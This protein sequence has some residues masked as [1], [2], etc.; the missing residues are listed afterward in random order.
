LKKEKQNISVRELFRENL[1]KAEII[2]DP[3]LST[4]IMR[5]VARREFFRF[6]PARLN[7]YYIGGLVA[8][9]IATAIIL[10]SGEP[11]S[12]QS[13]VYT[14]VTGS[15]TDTVLVINIGETE[16]VIKQPIVSPSTYLST[17]NKAVITPAKKEESVIS[18][19]SADK[20]PERVVA[21]QRIGNNT[22]PNKNVTSGTSSGMNM[23]HVSHIYDGTI[24]EQSAMEGCIPLKIRFQI[25][26]NTYDSCRWTFGDGGYSNEK[27]PEWI[28]DDEGEYKVILELYGKD[29]SMRTCYSSVTVY[30]KPVA[31]FEIFPE[32]GVI[33]DNEINFMN[34]SL[35]AIHFI[36]DFGDGTGSEL[37]EPRHTYTRSG[38]Y[39]IRLLVSSEYG[40]S[41]SLTVTNVFSDSKDRIDFPNAFIP[42]SQ[43][44]SGGYYSSKSDEAAH[45]F[46]PGYVDVSAYH[47]RIYS[48]VGVLI[49]ESNDI[50]IG[51]DGYYKGVLCD[52]GVYIWKVRGNFRNGESFIRMGDVTLLKE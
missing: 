14:P 13:S 21:M 31:R 29:G 12:E 15:G 38:N 34:Y 40:C 51:W 37:F 20:T 32:K 27:N 7:I 47:L 22:I 28:F 26:T 11:E 9:S 39:N 50:H 3:L 18:A 16:S 42:N 30:P 49:F 41:D 17:G 23:L 36:W 8:V 44:P 2:P 10:L 52:P 48:K 19:E 5:R 43:G 4:K 33:P 35:N 25:K 6:N 1:G 45:V 46:H 24:I